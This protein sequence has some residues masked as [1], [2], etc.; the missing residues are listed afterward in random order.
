MTGDSSIR[1]AESLRE[2][3]EFFTILKIEQTEKMVPFITSEST[4]GQHVSKFVSGVDVFGLD[5]R[6][7]NDPDKQATKRNSLDS[8]YVSLRRTSAF[9]DHLDDR[10]VVFKIVK[11]RVVARKFCVWTDVINFCQTKIFRLVRLLLRSSDGKCFTAWSGGAAA[12]RA[13]RGRSCWLILVSATGS[14]MG[15]S[16]L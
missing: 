15:K 10:F 6:V 3:T 4:L 13:A 1:L 14:R 8:G 7:T 9:D 12:G 2:S 5:L 11:Q 16:R